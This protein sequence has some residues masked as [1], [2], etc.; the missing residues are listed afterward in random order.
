MFHSVVLLS[1]FMLIFMPHLRS[2]FDCALEQR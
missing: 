1:N 2:D